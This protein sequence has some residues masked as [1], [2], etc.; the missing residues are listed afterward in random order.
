MFNLNKN[1]LT[2]NLFLICHKNLKIIELK[3]TNKQNVEVSL[4]KS[5]EADLNH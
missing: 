1:M 5:H 4:K 2:G 3:F